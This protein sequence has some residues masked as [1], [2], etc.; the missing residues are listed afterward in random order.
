MIENQMVLGRPYGEPAS[1]RPDPADY[2]PDEDPN[3]GGGHGGWVSGDYH[4]AVTAQRDALATAMLRM[5]MQ[6]GAGPH[7]DSERSAISAARA[8]LAGV[9]P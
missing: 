3:Y 7:N 6:F 5:L 1:R 8:A 9:R 2:N 4:R